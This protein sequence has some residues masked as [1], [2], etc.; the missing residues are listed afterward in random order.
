[1]NN[2][3]IPYNFVSFFSYR[4]GHTLSHVVIITIC[5][6]KRV[7]HQSAEEVMIVA[8]SQVDVFDVLDDD[9]RGQRSAAIENDELSAVPVDRF[10]SLEEL[11]GF[12]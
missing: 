2:D 9:L 12:A 5:I 7:S 4:L 10:Q 8:T 6:N 11:N 1:M 3:A